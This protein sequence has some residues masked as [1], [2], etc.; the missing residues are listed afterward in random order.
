MKRIEIYIDN[1]GSLAVSEFK[2]IN[3]QYEKL[4]LRGMQTYE[5][6]FYFILINFFIV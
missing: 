5:F 4:I 2:D 6:I 1:N 3:S